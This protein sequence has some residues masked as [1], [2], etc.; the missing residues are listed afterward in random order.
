[1]VKSE[2]NRYILF[3]VVKENDFSIEPKDLLYSIW[4][5]IWKFFGMREANKVGLWL[6]QYDV[7]NDLGLI[8]CSHYTK[9]LIISALALV[10][11]ISGK[12][13]ILSPIRTSGTIRSI[14]KFHSSLKS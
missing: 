4:K 5:S 2:R 11:N 13:V 14:K 6:I 7:E 10:N 3:Q 12:R 1:M 8:R 9:E